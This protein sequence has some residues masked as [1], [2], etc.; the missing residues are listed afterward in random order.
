MHT[1]FYVKK[2]MIN[3]KKSVANQQCIQFMNYYGLKCDK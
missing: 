2:T 3:F 1:L